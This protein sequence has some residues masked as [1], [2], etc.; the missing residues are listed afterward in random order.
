LLLCD[1]EKKIIAA[2]HAGWK[3]AYKGIINKVIKF[4]KKKGSV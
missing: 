3:G 4:M 1:D 2:I